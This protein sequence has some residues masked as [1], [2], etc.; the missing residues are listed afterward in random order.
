MNASGM[1]LQ[2]RADRQPAVIFHGEAFALMKYQNKVTGRIEWLWNSRDGVTPFVIDDPLCPAGEIDRFV[3]RQAA[4][5]VDERTEPDPRHMAHTD[6][7]EDAF[8]PNFIPTDGTRIFMSWSD[9]PAPYKA[10]L[11]ERWAAY[12]SATPPNVRAE[13][14]KGEPYDMKPDS[15]VLVVVTIDLVDYFHRL[16]KDNPFIPPERASGLIKPDRPGLVGIKP[17]GKA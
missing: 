17:D 5:K 7:G 15:P 9:A 2:R 6:P 13:L 3:K 4:G 1:R 14:E 8:L 12:L 11:R 10:Q 16:A